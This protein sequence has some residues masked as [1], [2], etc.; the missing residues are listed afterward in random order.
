MALGQ[1]LFT[2]MHAKHAG[3]VLHA[4]M[5]TATKSRLFVV[6]HNISAYTLGRINVLIDV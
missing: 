2:C 4:F 3:G 5:V 1:L 6:Y